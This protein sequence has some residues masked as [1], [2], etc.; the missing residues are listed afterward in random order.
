MEL[1]KRAFAAL[2]GVGTA[3]KVLAFTGL[4][5]LI[6]IE[7]MA[8]SSGRRGFGPH[9]PYTHLT[10]VRDGSAQA[11]LSGTEAMI[12][13]IATVVWWSALVLFALVQ[14]SINEGWISRRA[15]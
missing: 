2:K 6:L 5:S 10:T 13:S 15:D 11:W 9:G 7:I 3:L 4:A 14:I 12:H 8:L 1:Q